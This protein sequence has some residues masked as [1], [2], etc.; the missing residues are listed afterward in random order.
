MKREN[1]GAKETETSEIHARIQIR[2]TVARDVHR[3]ARSIT[4]APTWRKARSHKKKGKV[5]ME[6]TS[7]GEI[8]STLTVN[9][10]GAVNAARRGVLFAR[11]YEVRRSS[12]RKGKRTSSLPARG[13]GYSLRSRERVWRSVAF[14]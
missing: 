14:E 1:A 5:G 3:R 4:G 10:L 6:N 8:K 13:F 12:H 9:V 7:G 11:E 2:T